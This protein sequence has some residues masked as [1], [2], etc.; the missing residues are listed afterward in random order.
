MRLRRS[1]AVRSAFVAILVAIVF[2]VAAC[3]GSPGPRDASPVASATVLM[4]D[5][6]FQPPHIEVPV[7]TTVTFT[8]ADQVPH[9]V[10]FDDGPG[11]DNLSFGATFQRV[12]ETPGTYDY[13]CTIH[14]GMVG[15]VSVVSG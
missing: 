3:G 7:R 5:N 13:R 8:N 1:V 11:S 15:R 2:V 4:K 14:V 6:L 12:F 10:K 9:N